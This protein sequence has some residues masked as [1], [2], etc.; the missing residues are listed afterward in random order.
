MAYKWYTRARK[1]PQLIGR[2]PD[3]TRI[4][5]GPYT[6]TQVLGGIG[7]CFLTS[8]ILK[9]WS[10][11]DIVSSAVVLLLISGSVV[12]FLGKLPPG[13]RNPL[14][15][16][17][18]V[19]RLF[20]ARGYRLSGRPMPELKASRVAVDAVVAETLKGTPP[21]G[22]AVIKPSKVTEKPKSQLFAAARKRIYGFLKSRQKPVRRGVATARQQ[23]VASTPMQ[24]PQQGIPPAP[25]PAL[26]G[27][28]R[29]LLESK[30]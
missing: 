12:F 15:Y 7:A 21:L 30:S 14:I 13:M 1:F 2:T 11:G 17:K 27:V 26:T 28:Q 3:G 22:L 25:S 16:L 18:G 5:G 9:V 4:P 24:M 29:L 20:F 6:V 10:P 19:L 23:T 8:Q